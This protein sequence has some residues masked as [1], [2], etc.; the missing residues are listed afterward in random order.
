[1]TFSDIFS[2]L[3]ELGR[4]GGA[5]SAPTDRQQKTDIIIT[6]IIDNR[7]SVKKSLQKNPK[8]V[9]KSLQNS[10]NAKSCRISLACL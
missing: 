10:K 7:K 5:R 4:E 3:I 6:I 9:K 8:T 2:K 1:M